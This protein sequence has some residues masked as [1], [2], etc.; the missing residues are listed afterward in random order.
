MWIKTQGYL[1]YIKIPSLS[2]NHLIVHVSKKR[3]KDQESIQ[4]SATPNPEY[5]FTI[6]HHKREPINQDIKSRFQDKTKVQQF[7]Q[8]NTRANEIP[9]AKLRWTGQQTQHQAPTLHFV[10]THDRCMQCTLLAGTC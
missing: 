9:T 1:A 7:I 8:Q 10:F 5:R 2:M 4:S 3:G 6:R